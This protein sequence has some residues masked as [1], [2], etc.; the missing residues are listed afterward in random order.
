MVGNLLISLLRH[1]DRVRSAS[2]AQLVNVIAPIM[3][4][5]EGPVWKQT[6]FHPFALTSKFAQG[7]VLR[8]IIDG[9]TIHS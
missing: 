3:T 8:V 1:T 9:P 5:P 2:Q 7:D 4:E 6:I